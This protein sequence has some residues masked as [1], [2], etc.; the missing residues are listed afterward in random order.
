MP[1]TPEDAWLFPGDYIIKDT[2]YC[3]AC[4][5]FDHNDDECPG[6]PAKRKSLITIHTFQ[7]G[8]STAYVF[9]QEYG[10]AFLLTF[11]GHVPHLWEIERIDHRMFPKVVN[12]DNERC[13]MPPSLVIHLKGGNV[14]WPAFEACGAI[15]HK[16][17]FAR[18][19]TWLALR[20]S[21]SR[22]HNPEFAVFGQNNEQQV[23]GRTI[24]DLVLDN[25]SVRYTNPDLGSQ[26]FRFDWLFDY[27]TGEL[28][29]EPVVSAAS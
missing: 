21:Y 22:G 29:R 25:D 23:N 10:K 13:R 14:H 2:I 19:N 26:S 5:T 28:L 6:S 4:G 1:D 18:N 7:G 27:S 20:K 16:Q 3:S 8:G 15:T 12:W 11:V 17:W 24:T 9:E